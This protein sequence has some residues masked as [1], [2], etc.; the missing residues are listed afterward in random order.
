MLLQARLIQVLQA[1]YSLHLHSRPIIPAVVLVQEAV[2]SP[3][4]A[5]EAAAAAVGKLFLPINK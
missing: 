4:E 2:V 5:V 1:Q 3:V